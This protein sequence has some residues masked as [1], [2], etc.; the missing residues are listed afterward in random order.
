MLHPLWTINISS[1]NATAKEFLLDPGYVMGGGGSVTQAAWGCPA[2]TSTIQ[3]RV[4]PGGCRG[5]Q[6]Q[7]NDLGGFAVDGLPEGDVPSPARLTIRDM[8]TSGTRTTVAPADM[9]RHLRPSRSRVGQPGGTWS[10]VFTLDKGCTISGNVTDNAVGG[11]LKDVDLVEVFN[12]DGKLYAS[13]YVGGGYG[14]AYTTWAL[15]SG[16]Y[17]VRTDYGSTP[18]DYIDEWYNDKGG[19]SLTITRVPTQLLWAHPT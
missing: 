9:A 5:I 16:T 15:P 18:S 10:I 7:T 13:S 4:V 3:V 1:S 8:W 12:G 2:F 11:A 14:T 19:R 6:A 17:Y